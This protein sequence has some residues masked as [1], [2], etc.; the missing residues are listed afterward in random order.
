MKGPKNGFRTGVHI[1]P[2]MRTT[3]AEAHKE[4]RPLQNLGTL[5]SSKKHGN[6]EKCF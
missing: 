3:C 6:A 2:Y 4:T 5:D 1:L